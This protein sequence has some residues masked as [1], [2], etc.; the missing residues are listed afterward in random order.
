VDQIVFAL[1]EWLWARLVFALG[2]VV[3]A[4]LVV[5]LSRCWICGWITAIRPSLT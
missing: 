5:L 1:D 4:A 3:T 2:A